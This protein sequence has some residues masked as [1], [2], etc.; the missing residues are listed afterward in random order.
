MGSL[1]VLLNP[2]KHWG[3]LC[4]LLITKPRLLLVSIL[5]PGQV[6][7]AMLSS[8]VLEESHPVQIYSPHKR[9]L[10]TLNAIDIWSKKTLHCM[11]R[12]K[13][14]T[15]SGGRGGSGTL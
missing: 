12:E 1:I 10:L 4:A 15:G 7:G 11:Y 9:E 5:L 13:G 2:L 8:S 3:I 14:V 6:T